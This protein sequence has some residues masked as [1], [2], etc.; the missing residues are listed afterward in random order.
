MEAKLVKSMAST[1]IYPA[2]TRYLADLA[3]TATSASEIGVEFDNSV[4]KSVSQNING[5]MKAVAK[6]DKAMAKTFKTEEEH[7]QF[8]ANDIRGLMDETRSYADA[9]ETEVADDM[10]PLPTYY[11]MLNIK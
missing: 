3:L 11:E 6:L 5:M 10:W 9:L 8:C 4:A 1:S 2:A 7:M